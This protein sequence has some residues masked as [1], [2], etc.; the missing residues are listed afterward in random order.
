M[1]RAEFREKIVKALKEQVYHTT[2][3]D[4]IQEA[5]QMVMD[6]LKDVDVYTLK[7]MLRNLKYVFPPSIYDVDPNAI[8]NTLLYSKYAGAANKDGDTTHLGRTGEEMLLQDMAVQ[9]DPE[10]EANGEADE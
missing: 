9:E 10:G 2:S 6:N 8:R 7:R 5:F 1:Q 4:D 3:I